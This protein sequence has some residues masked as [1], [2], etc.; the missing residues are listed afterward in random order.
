MSEWSDPV[1]GRTQKKIFENSGWKECPD[2]VVEDRKYSID[3]K[4][5]RIV[6]K[7]V[8]GYDYCTIIGNTPH[9]LNAVTSWSIKVLKSR[10]NDG[11][12]I[13]IGVAPFDINQ[14]GIDN[15]ENCGW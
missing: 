2:D 1:K 8:D 6:T 11:S 3:E 10:D 13:F 15:S 5:P 12:G 14:N 7:V 9:P 4:N